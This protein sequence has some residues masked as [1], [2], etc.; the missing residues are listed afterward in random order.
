M[1]HPNLTHFLFSAIPAWGHIRPFCILA[2][3]LVSENENIVVTMILAPNFLD[4]AHSEISAEFGEGG[5]DQARRR[6]RVLS[7]VQSTSY[8]GFEIMQPMA[9]TYATAYQTLSEGK[10][11]TCAEKNTVF[12]AV[13]APV[14][15]ILDFVALPQLQATRA[16]TGHS[17]PIIAWV[18]GHASAVVRS[19]GPESLGGRGDIGARV[20]AELART[21]DSLEEISDKIY[22]LTDGTAVKV[23]GLPTMYDHEFFPQTRPFN[24]PMAMIIRGCRTVLQECDEVFISSAYSFEEQSIAAAKSWFSEMKKDTYVIGP[25]LPFGYGTVA[26]SSRGAVDVEAFLDKMLIQQGGNSV[27]FVSFGTV[28]WPTVPEYVDEV[29]EALIETKFS[30]VFSFASPFAKVSDDLNAKVKLSG[31]GIITPWAPQQFILNHPATGWFLTHCGHNGIMES[32]AVGVPLIA[33]PFEADQ[34]GAAAHLTEN[35]NVAFELI[36]VRTGENGLKPLYRNG[37]AAKGTREAV[38][39]EI[40]EVI[41]ACR[42]QKG[43]E[44]RKNAE[45]IKDEFAEAWRTDGVSRKELHTFLEKY[46]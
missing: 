23:A 32:L 46:V 11:I 38:G 13:P 25:L 2:A 44:L 27:I 14:V 7:T 29:V 30:F 12:D 10:S 1:F 5:S 19:L 34:P 43:E 36:E 8:N 40:R 41:D 17:V 31:L 37:R 20:D 4:K 6:I 24:A 16:I 35:L 21:G 3:R 42:G 26:Q 18:T 9:E 33:W 39:I 45:G 15:V 22:H 28:Y